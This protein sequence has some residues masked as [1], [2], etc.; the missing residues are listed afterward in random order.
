MADEV[1]NEDVEEIVQPVAELTAEEKAA[2]WEKW[3]RDEFNGYLDALLPLAKAGDVFT[4]YKAHKIQTTETGPEYSKS[5]AAG[6]SI[7]LFLEFDKPIDITK[8]R[9]EQE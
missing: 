2:M 7:T 1:K 6:V 8:P 5:L 9:D 3:I 4:S